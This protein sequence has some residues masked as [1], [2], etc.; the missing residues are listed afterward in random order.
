MSS[1]AREVEGGGVFS[2]VYRGRALYHSYYTMNTCVYIY[3]EREI[4]IH[5]YIM[6]LCVHIYI[7]I[8]IERYIMFVVN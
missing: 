4:H 8:Y 7:Y 1:A 5:T 2:D 3:I 6:S